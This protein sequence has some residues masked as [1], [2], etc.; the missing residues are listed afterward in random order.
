LAITASGARATK[1]SLARLIPMAGLI[2]KED[3]LARLAK[4]VAKIEG[5]IGRIESKLANGLQRGDHR[6]LFNQL[7]FRFRVAFQLLAL[8]G[9]HRFRRRTADPDGGPHQQRR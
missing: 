4:E 3:E 1:P 9:D 2:N 8:F 7:R 5:E 6:L